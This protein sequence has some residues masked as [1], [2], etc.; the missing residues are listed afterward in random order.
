MT[1]QRA[2]DRAAR[3]QTILGEL[4]SVQQFRYGTGRDYAQGL[5]G[6]SEVLA[7]VPKLILDKPLLAKLVARRFPFV[8]VDESQDT[9]AEVVNALRHIA[10]KQPKFALGFFGD[11]MQK[12]YTTGIG[13]IHVPGGPDGWSALTKPENFRSSLRVLEL[14]N[15]IRES[16]SDALV[17]ESGL[18]ETDQR[19]GELTFVVLPTSE[20]RSASLNHTL[21]WLRDQSA[22]GAG[23]TQTA[24]RPARYSSSP[25]GW[26]LA[27]S[28]STD[29]TTDFMPAERCA[30]PSTKEPHG[31]SRSSG[32]PSSRS[33]QR[34]ATLATSWS[35]Y[36]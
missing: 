23:M 14:I 20:N 7:M 8:L 35:R 21:Q 33:S 9:F 15:A 11:P 2:E 10:E 18:A 28:G 1:M 36:S 31:P 16:A 12:V 32:S 5:L 19:D 34:R 30:T 29:S 26:P 24:R 25:T 3:Y 6:R 27:G 22:I 4:S 13:A 17:Q